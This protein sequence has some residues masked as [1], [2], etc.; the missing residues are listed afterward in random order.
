[1][2]RKQQAKT[3]VDILMTLCLL[4]LMPYELIGEAIHEWI[5]AGMFLLFIIH[6]ILNRKWTGNLT[7]GRYTP[8]RII[9]TILVILIL[10]CILGSMVSGIILS[11]HVFVFLEI[12]GLSAPARVIHMTCAYWGFVLMSLH[13]GIH[14]GMMMGMAGKIFPKPSK[15]RTWILR[16]AGIGI[17]GYGVYAFIKRDIL[18]YLLMQVQY[19]FFNFEEPVIFFILDYMAAMGLFVFIGYYL[20]KGLA[21]KRQGS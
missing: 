20:R 6:H 14:W 21:W 4:F 1:M 19:V 16:L 13:L 11:R 18:S 15:A 10:I 5:G 17:A 8:L 7:K 12:R 9:Q 3:A 2:N